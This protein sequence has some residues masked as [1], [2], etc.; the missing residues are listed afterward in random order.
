M[1]AKLIILKDITEVVNAEYAKSI[2]KVSEIMVAST[3][4]DM[5]TPLNNI[6]NM[7]RLLEENIKDSV[8]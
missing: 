7:L 8:I 1:Q 3:S 2:E 4:H 6:I 5:R